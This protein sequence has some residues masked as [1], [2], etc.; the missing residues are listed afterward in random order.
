M[1]KVGKLD[2]S[3]LNNK[4]K[5]NFD[6]T[7]NGISKPYWFQVYG[8]YV[9]YLCNERSDSVL[10]ALLP[11]AMRTKQ[12][13]RLTTPITGELY[14]NITEHYLPTLCNTLNLHHCKIICE[15][16]DEPLDNYGKVGTGMSLGVD[17]FH[18]LAK[19]YKHQLEQF[20]LTHLCVFDIGAFDFAFYANSKQ[21]VYEDV[22]TKAQE[23]AISL[24]L[25]FLNMTSNLKELGGDLY[26]YT[27]AFTN[28]NIACVFAIQKL[29]RTY[30]WA[31]GYQYNQFAITND[32]KS[33]HSIYDLLSLRCFS[34]SKL[35]LYSEG[36]SFSRSQ[37]LS[38]VSEFAPALEKLHVCVTESYNCCTCFKCIRTLVSLDAIGKLHKFEKIFNVDFYE[39]NKR[40]YIKYFIVNTLNTLNTAALSTYKESLTGKEKA[41]FLEI[42]EELQSTNS[43]GSSENSNNACILDVS[44]N[45]LLYEINSNKPVASLLLKK[46]AVCLILAE[47]GIPM[48]TKYK[49]P[50][51]KKFEVCA[52]FNEG[53]YF[54]LIDIMHGVLL[55]SCNDLWHFAYNLYPNMADKINELLLNIGITQTVIESDMYK[56]DTT[57]AYDVALLVKYALNN[58]IVCSI[59]STDVYEC[60]NNQRKYIFENNNVLICHRNEHK[61]NGFPDRRYKYCISALSS[62][63]FDSYEYITVAERQ[64]QKHVFVQLN[65]NRIFKK[66][67]E[68][69]LPA[70]HARH[71]HEAYF[72]NQLKAGET[73]HEKI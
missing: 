14:Y 30:Y 9:K 56:T 2:I 67:G 22:T 3:H 5:L 43:D 63:R 10:I 31:S 24:D 73:C 41:I 46:I 34:I 20:R 37:K 52:N 11:L 64:N 54:H 40:E 35:N 57:T 55:K 51:I 61:T 29:F 62:Y 23:L 48:D 70:K 8:E 49:M 44:T 68:I 65:C 25:S 36:A 39:N 7:I 6:I 47:S 42:E 69:I 26:L 38:T 19:H 58:N 53:E 12:D 72:N 16:T 45:N 27:Q 18:S 21:D 33:D 71:I 1:I 66:A 4:A 13:I 28:Y 17:S 59:M 32:S 15:T 60:A 50:K